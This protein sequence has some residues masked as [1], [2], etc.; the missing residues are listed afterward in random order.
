MVSAV[1]LTWVP[2]LDPTDDGPPTFPGF[3]GLSLQEQRVRVASTLTFLVGL[4]QV[5]GACR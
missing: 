3:I 5:G 2:S 1:V 4:F